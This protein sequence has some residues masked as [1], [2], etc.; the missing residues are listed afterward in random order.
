MLTSPILAIAI[1]A[2]LYSL[3][4][5]CRERSGI[6]KETCLCIADGSLQP[7]A[8]GAESNGAMMSAS[9]IRDHSR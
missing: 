2:I 5:F 6:K 4:R 8:V 1:A 9:G 3:F 7:I